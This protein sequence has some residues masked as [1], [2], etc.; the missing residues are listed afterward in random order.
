MDDGV[1][2][3][4]LAVISSTSLADVDTIQVTVTNQGPVVEELPDITTDVGVSHDLVVMASDVDGYIASYL[5]DFGDD[6][7]STVRDPT[8][9]WTS[10]GPHQASVN[11]TDDDGAYTEITFW[12]NVTN[13]V[14]AITFN[15]DSVRNEGQAV[16]V[17]GSGTVEPGNDIVSWQWDWDSDGT[18]DNATGPLS[19]TI[20]DKPGYYNITL[21]VT[22]GEGST[23]ETVREVLIRNVGPTAACTIPNRGIMEGNDVTY[24]CSGSSEPGDD[25]IRYYFDWESDGVYDFNTTEAVVN[26]TF[27][28]VGI[29]TATVM[30]ED[31]DG[32]FDD[33]TSFWWMRVTVSNAPPLVNASESS[34]IEGE[35]TTITVDAYEPGDNLV[36]FYWDFDGDY[37]PDAHTTTPY[38]NHTFW[39]AGTFWVWVNVT[40]EDHTNSTP[41]WG[42]GEIKVNI[43]DVAPK[44][45]VEGGQATEGE[46]TP[47]T[48]TM[49]GTEEN[50]STFHFDLD[51]DGKFE[52]SSTEWT[53]MLTF[54]H[55]G[56]I[57]CLIRVVDTDGTEGIAL[58][59]VYVYDVAPTLKGPA[60]MLVSEGD[61]MVVEVTAEEPGMNIVRYEFDW[62]A[63]GIADDTT[64][65]PM[66]TH[67]YTSMGAK[68]IVVTV[69]DEDGSQGSV[70]IQ[71]LVANTPPTADAGTPGQ[72][73]EG[74]PVELNASLS[75][76]P[77]DDI[78]AYEWDY[79]ADG[80][81]DF[82][83]RDAAHWHSWDT[84]GLYTIVLRAIDAD[85]TFD[86]DTATVVIEDTDPV[87]SISV[88]VQPEDRPTILDGSM[89]SDPGGI[90]MYEWNITASGQRV[91]RATTEPYFSF[92]FDRK[93]RY[94][95]TLTVTDGEGSTNKV[96]YVVSIDDVITN[97]PTVTWEAPT[98]VMEDSMF[99]LRAWP[100]DP[101]P[102][103]PDLL[104]A[105]VF[106]FSWNLGDGSVVRHGDTVTHAYD[107][108]SN[109]PYEV[110]LVVIDEDND[111]ITVM[112]ANISVLNPA[113]TIGSITPI[114]VKAGGNGETKVEATDGTTPSAELT[115]TLDPNAPDWAT[116]DGDSLK[117]SPGKGVAGA[118]YMIAVT[119]TDGLGASSTAQ[120]PV[121]VTK[122]EVDS[123]LG[124]GMLIGLMVVFMLVAI[125]VA[126]LVSTR[127]GAGVGGGGSAKD[128]PPRE[129]EY[130]SLYGKEPSRRKVRPVAK[131]A[132]EQVEVEPSVAETPSSSV[133]EVPDYATA[134]AAAGYSVVEEE[135]EA[136]PPL[137]S[138]MASTKVEEVHLEEKVVEPPPATPPEW[139]TSKEPAPA[140][141]YK[142]S[143]PPSGK[144]VAFK[145]TGRPR[146]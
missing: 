97:P 51:G 83:T 12:V 50:I 88:D 111:R 76:E 6:S 95:I 49:R 55:T 36:G 47:F 136:E 2:T 7:T 99:T 93:V 132:S 140:Q 81:F 33:Y 13:V 9:T 42:G 112:V 52:V 8:H 125:V 118:T 35:N 21:K 44:P 141:P 67:A 85:G 45:A 84:P 19:W 64:T 70:G 38:V 120:I 117:V 129:K 92:T 59:N 143:Q 63:D 46:A 102:D 87:A 66:A 82:T 77:G 41:S 34:G 146:Q 73:F 86:D 5:W 78:V 126:V 14:P 113:P 62:N 58:F 121:V 104:N 124:S 115:F 139:Q 103:D 138:W 20:Y 145:G 29:F 56:E 106:E 17:D 105:R 60:F 39:E 144:K 79:D 71:V 15:S 28:Q 37:L 53:T 142:F 91:D 24:D 98:L 4:S 123:G 3:V 74:E 75:T 48:V 11:V 31:E 109:L 100:E 108:A 22:D 25:I 72:A 69:V 128:I 32:T 23:N 130:D 133:P 30:V 65:E 114:T 10:D 40:D 90:V 101:F 57:E 27:Y 54:I 134:A 96:E 116:M 89:S 131:V 1:Y 43:S 127:M 94:D 26:H 122:E 16:R 18:F 61:D 68:R 135:P 119:V 110:T 137:P 107:R 80:L